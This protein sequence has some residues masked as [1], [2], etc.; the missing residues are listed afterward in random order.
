MHQ[1]QGMNTRY[2]AIYHMACAG[3]IHRP[4][5]AG[6]RNTVAK[7]LRY[8]RKLGDTNML[9]HC[10]YHFAHIGWPIRLRSNGRYL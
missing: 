1:Y 9:A 3:L 4:Y 7:C 5:S 2:P 6:T 10:R 8:Y